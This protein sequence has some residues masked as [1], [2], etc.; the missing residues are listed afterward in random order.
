[1]ISLGFVDPALQLSR[2]FL[3]PSDRES[4]SNLQEETKEL[5]RT[6]RNKLSVGSRS[7]AHFQLEHMGYLLPRPA[8][9]VKDPR[10]TSFTPD[11]WQRT[12]L[13]V[14]DSRESALVCAPTSSGKTFISYYCMEKVMRDTAFKDGVLV[15]VA[16]T[17]DLINQIAAQ[18]YG[19]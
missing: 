10:I 17:K 2:S 18:V 11:E 1:M 4:Y 5:A 8:P 7:M 9:K 12:L 19:K 6:F 3:D 15:F 13:D 14:V 16:P